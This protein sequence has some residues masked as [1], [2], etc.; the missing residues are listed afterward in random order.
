[1]E[2]VAKSP[3]MLEIVRMAE[4]VAR[5]DATLLITGESGTGKDL[6]ARFVHERSRRASAPLVKIDCAG[7]AQS[8]LEAELFGYER[9]AFTGANRTMPGRIEGAQGGTL[10]LD[11][12]A[13]LSAD[14]QAKL[15]RVIE[16][17]EFER[18]GGRRALRVDARI[19]ALTNVDLDGAVR[20]RA[21]REDLFH[22]LNVVRLEIPPLRARRADVRELARRFLV[23]ARTKHGKRI[24]SFSTEA[25]RLLDDYDFPGNVRELQHIV[26][27]A[28]IVCEGD[29]IEVADLPDAVRL[30]ARSQRRRRERPTLAEV[31]A[32]YIRE[33]LTA[34]RGNKSEAARILGISR[35]NLYEKIARYHIESVKR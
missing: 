35:K 20:R 31:E 2:L 26:E 33:V 32:E 18:L 12:V 4:R 24:K 19:I 3:A 15:L 7:L 29:R 13:Q 1:M 22:R 21:F 34:A 25:L 6:L 9:G 16:R 10:V 11:E 17:R 28:V 27:R 23:A 30:A 5:T 14:A 8:L